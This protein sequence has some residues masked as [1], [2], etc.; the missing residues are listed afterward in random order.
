MAA[1]RKIG[2]TTD[3]PQSFVHEQQQAVFE[4]AKTAPDELGLRTDDGDDDAGGPRFVRYFNP[5]LEALRAQGGSATPDKVFAWIK[6]HHDIPAA[7]IEEAL[8]AGSPSSRIWSPGR[9]FTSPR[10]V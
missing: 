6:D 5:V 7:E 8:R 1:A 2:L 9:A 4:W 3:N 10:L